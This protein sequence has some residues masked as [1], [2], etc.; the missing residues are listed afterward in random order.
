[1]NLNE[2][3]IKKVAPPTENS[4]AANKKFVDDEIAKLP[5]SDTGTLK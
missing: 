1:M 3:K 2:N 4:D 5:H